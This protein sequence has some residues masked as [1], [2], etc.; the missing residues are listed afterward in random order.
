MQVYGMS[1]RDI[2]TG[3]NK[4]ALDKMPEGVRVFPQTLARYSTK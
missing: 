3:P 4:I 2:L 1:A